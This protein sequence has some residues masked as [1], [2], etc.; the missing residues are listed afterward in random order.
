MQIHKVEQGTPE[1]LALR[2]G[3]P[4]TSEFSNL[5]TP[6][7]KA[8]TS[9]KAFA[10]GLAA[11]KLAGYVVDPT[12]TNFAMERGKELEEKA[13]NHYTFENEVEVETIG[14]VT[15]DEMTAGCSPDRFVGKDGLLEIK[16]PMKPKFMSCLWDVNHGK[17]PTDYFIQVQG[18]LMITERKWC[19][20]F[21]FHP[22]I[23][24]CCIRIEPDPEIFKTLNAQLKVLSGIRTEAIAMLN[25]E[26]AAA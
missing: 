13:A 16:C 10:L 19:D 11:D 18:Q 5:V 23:G 17:C 6:T 7:G 8:S 24:T 15:N 21:F 12:P 2:V 14:F 4:T 22:E 1:W 26:K 9:V 3:I 25:P 20:L